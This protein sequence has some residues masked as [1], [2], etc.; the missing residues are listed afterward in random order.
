[1]VAAFL[2]AALGAIPNYYE[3]QLRSR[4][5]REEEAL[6]EL[7]ALKR[8]A[9][10]RDIQQRVLQAEM[11]AAR[12][13]GPDIIWD[14]PGR[15][16][17]TTP[18]QVTPGQAPSMTRGVP[19]QGLPVDEPIDITPLSETV[20]PIGPASP[21]ERRRARHGRDVPPLLEITP[22]GDSPA[23]RRR[24]G[25]HGR[26]APTPG[27]LGTTPPATGAIADMVAGTAESFGVD[28]NLA[29]AI[30]GKE[31]SMGA[32][33]V[34]SVDGAVGV[35]QVLPS[36]AYQ[37]YEEYASS[38]DP[39][40]AAAAQRIGDA[41]ADGTFQTDNIQAQIDAGLLYLRYG[42]DMGA[43]DP[44]VLAAGYHGGMEG[45]VR[46]GGPSGAVDGLGTSNTA[47]ADD[48]AR[49]VN[50]SGARGA[51]PDREVQ[52]SNTGN[53]TPANTSPGSLRFDGGVTTTGPGPVTAPPA[54]RAADDFYTD[55]I[56]RLLQ[57]PQSPANDYLIAQY[58]IA[59]SNARAQQAA[60]AAE[61]QQELLIESLKAGNDFHNTPDGYVLDP[62][63]NYQ[64]I[65]TPGDDEDPPRWSPV[66][67]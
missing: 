28:P 36:T 11:E 33:A 5:M 35:A 37:M 15:T 4:K 13:R 57:Q 25:R 48:I 40:L 20:T 62:S 64:L 53:T 51:L 47:Y 67:R 26:I 24:Q 43:T 27:A 19:P 1:M 61:F 46:R 9:A 59:R 7:E 41:L 50:A 10:E 2:G 21:E 65:G 60:A 3:G 14:V 42:Q 49:Q 31:S 66:Y 12:A 63:G 18:G 32:N 56:N 23:E 39:E 44:R 6:L 45:A 30:V 58:Q 55:A 16:T 8:D 54:P 29:L 52:T 17:R 34:T 38:P 22:L